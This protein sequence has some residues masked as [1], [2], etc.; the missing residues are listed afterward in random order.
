MGTLVLTRAETYF[1]NEI[2]VILNYTAL[3]KVAAV[4]PFHKFRE[5]LQAL[6]GHNPLNKHI[7]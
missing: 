3:L 5:K 2:P 4:L 6:P 1:A 7:Y